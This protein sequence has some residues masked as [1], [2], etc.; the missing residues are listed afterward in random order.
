MEQK[1]N[2]GEIFAILNV[3]LVKGLFKWNRVYEEK[4]KA[5]K[6]TLAYLMCH[7]TIME[8]FGLKGTL[9]FIHL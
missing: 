9:K 4:L 7:D 2:W 6:K 3:D 8:W 1:Q 5:T